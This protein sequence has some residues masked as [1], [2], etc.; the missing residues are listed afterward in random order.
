MKNFNEEQRKKIRI[1][2]SHKQSHFRFDFY[3]LFG[4]DHVNFNDYC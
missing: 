4:F 3:R 1:V 2:I